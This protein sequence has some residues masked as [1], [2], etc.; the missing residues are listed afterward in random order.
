MRKGP[1]AT[2]LS[3][4]LRNVYHPDSAK[5]VAMSSSRK[6]VVF[7]G[8]IAAT[9]QDPA[10]CSAP[11]LQASF[12]LPRLSRDVEAVT[13][14]R[15]PLRAIK[16]ERES[17]SGAVYGFDM[18]PFDEV[19]VKVEAD[20]PV[21]AEAEAGRLCV[22]VSAIEIAPPALAAIGSKKPGR[23]KGSKSKPRVEPQFDTAAPPVRKEARKALARIAARS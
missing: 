11:P 20:A 9:L 22:R 23:P 16:V 15:S 13:R 5:P 2:I 7:H 8:V 17:E 18:D 14:P 12:R 4:S 1:R 21:E 3:D 6:T 10:H 19:E